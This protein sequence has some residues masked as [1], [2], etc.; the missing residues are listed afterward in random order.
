M[1]WIFCKKLKNIRWKMVIEC[2]LKDTLVIKN[3]QMSKNTSNGVPKKKENGTLRAIRK[4]KRAALISFIYFVEKLQIKTE[5][6]LS[7]SYVM[8]NSHMFVWRVPNFHMHVHC[9]H[10]HTHSLAAQWNVHQ[11]SIA[12]SFSLVHVFRCQCCKSHNCTIRYA[13]Y[14]LL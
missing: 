5:Q 1:I 11:I 14:E 13:R 2:L 3:I 10:T 9:T 7:E 6:S 4:K 8:I 12:R